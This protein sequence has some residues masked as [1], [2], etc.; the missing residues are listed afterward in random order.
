MK[1]E[2]RQLSWYVSAVL[3]R[4]SYIRIARQ[5]DDD[6]FAYLGDKLDGILVADCGCGP[7]HM[8][9][10][11]L[12]NGVG[13]LLAIDHNASMLR[14]L[15]ARVPEAVRANQVKT[16][17]SRFTPSIFS[18]YLTEI[19][20]YSGYGLILFKRSL[21]MPRVEALVLL[22]AAVA[23]LAS[24][25]VVVVIHGERSLRRYAFSPEMKFASHTPFHL[26]NR[27]FSRLGHFL[28]VGEYNLYTRQELMD[29]LTEAAGGN[30]VEIIPSKQRAYNLMAITA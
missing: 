28:G 19:D 25:G 30:P 10:R 23:S 18:E 20:A 29:L 21:Y 24:G 4:F 22:Q 6:L 26:I 11:L 2:R 9:E 8:A 5:I 1:L 15:E 16:V 13:Q 7:G 27:F 17:Q 3:Y 12:A 14:Q